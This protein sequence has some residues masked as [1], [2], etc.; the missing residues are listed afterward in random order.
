MTNQDFLV[1][2]KAL[3]PND[4]KPKPTKIQFLKSLT[5]ITMSVLRNINTDKTEKRPANISM[6]RCDEK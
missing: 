1:K 5:Y 4:L 3:T 2:G 6:G